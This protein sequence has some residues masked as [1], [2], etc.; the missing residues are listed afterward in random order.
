MSHAEI[1]L[2][3]D[4]GRIKPKSSSNY[5]TRVGIYECPYCK[6]HF[7][8]NIN[9]VKKG[10][11]TKC[12]KCGDSLNKH[13]ESR[14]SRVYRIWRAI[15]S[16]CYSETNT[17]FINYGGR[18]ITMCDSWV[19]SYTSF[20]DWA[21]ENRYSDDLTIDRKD[22]DGNYEPNNCRWV[23]RST[24]TRNTRTLRI[25]NTSGYRGVSFD[26]SRGKWACKITVEN[27]SIFIGRY[28]T[29][30]EAGIAY[31]NY[32]IDNNLEHT[33]NNPKTKAIA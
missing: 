12:R 29:A 5:K 14:N 21:L 23:N 24:Q 8:A 10:N 19:S 2:I 25:N 7:R 16:R 31:D 9:N 17:H 30:I 11:T 18:G 15:K 28:D 33:K 26:T 13:C 22:N 6:K 27:K 1:K 20:R 3:E 32:V 4:L